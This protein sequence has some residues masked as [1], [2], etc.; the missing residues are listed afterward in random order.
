MHAH[1]TGVTDV[2]SARSV[3]IMRRLVA[4]ST[5]FMYRTPSTKLRPNCDL[6]I[7]LGV[8]RCHGRLKAYLVFTW[9]RKINLSGISPAK[10]SLSGPNSVHVDMSRGDNVQG[11]FRRD[12]PFLGKMGVGTSFAES[13]FLCV[14]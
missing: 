13:E 2:V 5:I 6:E 12:R 9:W 4:Y 8:T 3:P 14:W 1:V 11:I 10:R 7:W